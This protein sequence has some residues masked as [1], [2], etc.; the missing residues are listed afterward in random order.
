MGADRP[1]EGREC[2]SEGSFI[3]A[4]RV[5]GTKALGPCRN[6]STASGRNDPDIPA[7]AA[8][9]ASWGP[10]TILSSLLPFVKGREERNLSTEGFVDRERRAARF[11][12]LPRGPR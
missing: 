4:S 1:L 7:R 5:V 3:G 6:S 9:A 11:R 12:A 10:G 8:R 2:P